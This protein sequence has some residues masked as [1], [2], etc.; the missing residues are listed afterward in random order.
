MLSLGRLALIGVI[1]V[2]THDSDAGLRRSKPAF[3]QGHPVW[4]LQ[5]IALEF[6]ALCFYDFCHEFPIVLK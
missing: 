4:V 2:G 1:T 3:C 5:V 6:P